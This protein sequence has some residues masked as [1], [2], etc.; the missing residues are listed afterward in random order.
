M[1]ELMSL[2]KTLDMIFYQLLFFGLTRSELKPA[3]Y[4]TQGEHHN[5]YINYIPDAVILSC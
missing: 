1:T 3:I 5:N 2:F 4:R